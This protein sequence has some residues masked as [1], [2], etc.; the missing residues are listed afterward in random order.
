MKKPSL[1]HEDLKNYRPVSNLPYLAK[2]T[3]KVVVGQLNQHMTDQNLHEPNQ[4]AYRKA[5]STE[6]ALLKVF[7]DILVAID[8]KECVMLILLD[9]SAAFDTVNHMALLERM[10]KQFGVTGNALSWFV[11]YFSD[12]S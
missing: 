5:H 4:S 2:L 9:L 11:S 1:N 12:R 6:T 7:N 10:E 3:E 8:H